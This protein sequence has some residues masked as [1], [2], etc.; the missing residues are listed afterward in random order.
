MDTIFAPATARGR[1]G[2]SIVRIS[3]PQAGEAARRLVASLPPARMAGLRAVRVGGELIDEALVLWFPAGASFTGEETVE[4]QLHG[5]PA[6]V[7]E[8]LGGLGATG[9][10]RLAEPGEFTRQ[11]LQNDRLDL[12]QVEGLG[13]L[14]AAETAMQR[15]QAQALLQGALGRRADL[16]REGLLRAS[17]LIEAT[18]DFSEEEL[19][20]SLI[21]EAG[22]AIGSVIGD[23]R[24]ELEGYAASERIR[25]GFE[26]AV[27]GPPN[28][29]KSTLIN[30][31][32]Q[33]DIA[34]TS[35]LAGT[36]RDIVEVRLDIAGLPV[37]LLDTAGMRETED[38]LE[39]LG[40][41]RAMAR[42]AEADLRIFL[43][44]PGEVFAHL[45]PVA[46]DIVVA[47]KAD[48]TSGVEDGVSGLTGAGVD[49]L[50]ER[51]RGV[52]AERVQSPATITRAR[53]R[54]A[55][56]GALADLERAQR[57]L[58][59]GRQ[60]PEVAAEELRAALRRLDSIVGR[61]DVE[62]VL[63]AVFASFCIGK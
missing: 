52:L 48:L 43:V 58:A 39:A 2:V 3:G 63:G 49:R 7:Q 41:A 14:L 44:P 29:G 12:A 46:G 50:I 23:L 42:A 16:W 38:A 13:D 40:V 59:D 21:E 33:R 51:V 32:A 54:A 9:L 18:I 55:V 25:D 19:P 11:A 28:A 8:V 36:T 35:P 53:H 47:A 37:T 30:R 17:A 45:A 27:V 5:S 6:V 26:V 15:R 10:A 20:P 34:I 61:I 4:F 24:R 1:A 22:V 56:A 31:L 57:V 60:G 62:Q